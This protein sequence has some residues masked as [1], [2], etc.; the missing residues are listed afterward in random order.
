MISPDYIILIASSLVIFALILSKASFKIG[1]PTLLLFLAIGML[2]GE[3]GL[4][5]AFNDP[6]SAQFV[7][8]IALTVILFFGG[9]GTDFKEIR[10]RLKEGLSLATFGV[11]LTTMLTGGFIYGIFYLLPIETKLNFPQCLLCAAVMSSTDSASVFSILRSKDIHL[12]ENIRPVLELESGS[13][14][15]MAYMLTIILIQFIQLGNLTIYDATLLLF[16]QFAMGVIVGI[17][18]GYITVWVVNKIN[19]PTP[20]LYPILVLGFAGLTYAVSTRLGG[21]GYLSVYLAGLI[22]GN[23]KL[24][25]KKNILG[26][27]DGFTWL[28]QLI[29]FLCLGLLVTPSH[30][31]S[32][33]V[34][35]ILIGLFMIFFGRPIATWLSLLPVRSSLSTKARHYISWMG[36]RGAAPI[37]F[38]TYP[39]MTNIPYADIIFN[40]FFFITLLSLI[41]QGSLATFLAEKLELIGEAS[42]TTVFN[43]DLPE[44]IKTSLSEIIVTKNML[45]EGM[46]LAEIPLPQK[47]LAIM[48]LRDEQYFVPSGETALQEDDHILLL[49]DDQTAL[50]EYYKTHNIYPYRLER[51][52]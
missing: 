16:M 22:V 26:F 42:P 50:L 52:R 33:A 18:L 7:G 15:P 9:M 17:S 3:D 12:K 31:L 30:L 14:D 4:G 32:I 6:E 38:A 2:A 45:Q 34:P 25:Y 47:T 35:A 10:P 8:L 5:I 24:Q 29:I 13:N 20:S 37:I 11:L 46:S 49:S 41:I 23:R 51:N 1:M 48:V 21:N 19:I 40:I 27:F 43:V 28:W 36:L 44:Q 39:L